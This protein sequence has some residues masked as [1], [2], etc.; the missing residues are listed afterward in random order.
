[1][2][3][4]QMDLAAAGEAKRRR[5]GQFSTR[6]RGAGRFAGSVVALVVFLIVVALVVSQAL[7]AGLL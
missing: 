4:G 1:M 7:R 5:E 6:G 2:I 3:E